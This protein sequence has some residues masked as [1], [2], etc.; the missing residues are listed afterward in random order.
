MLTLVRA[1]SEPG[2]MVGSEAGAEGERIVMDVCPGQ[3]M[4]FKC[5]SVA[6]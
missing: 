2:A 5:P 3:D 1:F 4:A 6:Y